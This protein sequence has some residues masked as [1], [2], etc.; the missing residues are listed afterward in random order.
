MKRLWKEFDTSIISFA[1]ALF[2]VTATFFY[3][4]VLAICECVLFVALFLTKWLYQKQVKQKLLYQVRT[5]A[6]EL[7]FER[8]EAFKKLTVA[9]AVI[10][11]NG[12]LVWIN[13]SFRETFS[14]DK[15]T[16]VCSILTVLNREGNVERLIEGKG[17]RIRVGQKYFAVYS[18]EA[19]LDDEELY[20]LYF[21]DETK[22]RKTERDY[23]DSRPSIMLC[24]I[25]NANEIYQTFKESECASI[26]SRIEQEI[27]SWAASYGA[28]CRK[29]SNSRMMIFVEERSLQKMIAEKFVIL[30]TI[31]SMSHDGKNCG[32]TLSIGV[33]KE[34]T[35]IAANDSAKQALDMAQSRGGDQVAIR[36]EAQYKFYGGVSAG[37]EKR[38][39]V[40]TRLISKSIATIINDSDNVL[41][42]GHRFSD[43][44]AFGG[45]VGMFA[46]AS[47]F[48]K[49]ANIVIDRDTTLAGPLVESF[50]EH[51]PADVLVSPEK[52]RFILGENTLV[53]V[54]DTHKKDFSEAPSL[55]DRA[56]KVMVIDHH[57]KSVGFIEDTVMFYHAPTASS[58]CEMIAEI[59]EYV[60]TAPFIDGITAQALLAGIMLDTR[61]FI[62]RTGVRTF[63]AA[64]YLRSRS[65]STIEA[66]KLFSNDMGVFHKRNAV[67]DNSHIYN[68]IFAISVADFKD[69]NIRLI[70]SQAADEMLNVEGIKASFVLYEAPGFVNISARS[71]GEV[72]VQ[73]IMEMLGGGGHQTMSACQLENA[74]VD[75]AIRRLKNAIDKYLSETTEVPK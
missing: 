44:D 22:L 35:L 37:F 23:Y 50:L 32:V 70:T 36:H 8:G 28:L 64:A 34:P 57:R 68:G 62:V 33:G 20:L 48:Q 5:I 13:D 49:R 66:K 24:V 46:I 39:K 45:S 6:D 63:E 61:N 15:K 16:P 43:F 17:Y 58:A 56:E 69:K 3:N 10:E 27:D 65:A 42:M 12:R 41:I 60:D 52:A 14:I 30:D 26:F 38:D 25:D 11:K 4:T 31:R 75:E 74:S 7:D 73:I 67:I 51:Y 18:S 19:E 71:Y 59:C 1:F 2:C 55:L 47:H 54:V 40:K 29:Y 9:C 72:N 21:F 53:I